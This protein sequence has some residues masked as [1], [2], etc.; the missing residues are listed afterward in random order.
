MT[1]PTTPT[2]ES[3]PIQQMAATIEAYQALREQC[4]NAAC[5]NSGA[6][7]GDAAW[8]RNALRETDIEMTVYAHGIACH[9]L[10]Y[11]LQTLDHESF[12]FTIPFVALTNE[13]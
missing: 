8:L 4:Y 7:M 1:M 6:L 13:P 2:D 5:R 10:V 11:S 12:E 3:A 9:G